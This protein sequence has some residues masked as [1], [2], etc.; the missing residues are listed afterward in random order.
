MSEGVAFC[1]MEEKQ[2]QIVNGFQH[3]NTQAHKIKFRI[4]KLYQQLPN[5]QSAVIKIFYMS[6]NAKEA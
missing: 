1:K 2:H 4:Q 3:L 6:K 5:S